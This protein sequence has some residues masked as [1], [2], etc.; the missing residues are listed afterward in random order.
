MADERGKDEGGNGAEAV[1]VGLHAAGHARLGRVVG[2]AAAFVV[3]VVASLGRPQAL[4]ALG[5]QVFRLLGDVAVGQHD[6][7]ELLAVAARRGA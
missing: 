5:D 7:A 4:G 1:D 2:D 6:H 3:A